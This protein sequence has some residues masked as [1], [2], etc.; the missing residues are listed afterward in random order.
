MY[1]LYRNF[2]LI[3]TK[4]IEAILKY[5]DKFYDIINDPKKV[6]SQINKACAI[7]HDHLYDLELANP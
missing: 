5:Y 1:S 2:D 3:E 6:K 4:R 7:N